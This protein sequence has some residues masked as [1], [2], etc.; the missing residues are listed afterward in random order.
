MTQSFI[1][2]LELFTYSPGLELL[3]EHQETSFQYYN[4]EICAQGRLATLPA[5]SPGSRRTWLP[6]CP[7]ALLDLVPANFVPLNP[8]QHPLLA[9]PC[10]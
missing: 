10:P 1:N 9:A 6:D 2:S 8:L 5:G 4:T 3:D 7:A